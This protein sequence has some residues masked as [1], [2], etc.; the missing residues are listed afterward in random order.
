MTPEQ[1]VMIKH[2]LMKGEKSM[3]IVLTGFQ[4]EA[5]AVIDLVANQR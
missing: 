5:G 4:I 1:R 2:G 3:M